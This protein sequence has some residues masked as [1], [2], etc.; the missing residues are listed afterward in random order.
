MS[1]IYV[2]GVSYGLSSKDK[3]YS[4]TS[5]GKRSTSYNTFPNLINSGGIVVKYDSNGK[6]DWISQLGLSES[7]IC[8]D[9]NK[10]TYPV[11][12]T[13][14]DTSAEP[15]T[16]IELPA[17][18]PNYVT[19]NTNYV[20]VAG[21]YNSN[22][23]VY[24]GN[25]N[26]CLCS[27]DTTICLPLTNTDITNGLF[28][29]EY[30]TNGNCNWIA[31]I[32]FN[33]VDCENSVVNIDN[34]ITDNTYVYL[35]GSYSD[36]SFYLYNGNSTNYSSLTNTNVANGLFLTQYDS[37]GNCSWTA[38]ITAACGSGYAANSI[39]AS[40]TSFT[41]STTSYVYIAAPYKSPVLFYYGNSSTN[42]LSLKNSNV[43]N[44][45]FI[46]KYDQNGSALSVAQ[47]T[48]G[49]NSI[50]YNYC[51]TSD[52]DGNIYVAGTYKSS[53]FLIYNGNSTS[54]SCLKNPTI[55]CGAF[56]V[57][58]NSDLFFDYSSYYYWVAQIEIFSS[59]D[60]LSSD[61]DADC[62]KHHRDDYNANEK[63]IIIN[64]IVTDSHANVYI[65]VLCNKSINIY[66]G[67]STNYITLTNDSNNKQIFI[68]KYNNYGQ[69]CW[70]FKILG[71]DGFNFIHSMSID[72][73]RNLGITGEFKGKYLYLYNSVNDNYITIKNTNKDYSNYTNGIFIKYNSCGEYIFNTQYGSSKNQSASF[74]GLSFSN[75]VSPVIP[76]VPC[77][78]TPCS[79]S[80]SSSPASSP[81]RTSQSCSNKLTITVPTSPDR[82]RR[83]S[84][85]HS[86]SPSPPRGRRRRSSNSHSR[87]PSPSRRPSSR[88]CSP[89]SE[90]SHVHPISN[91][92][93]VENTPIS[94]DQGVIPIQEIDT[95]LHTIHKK[96][97]IAITKTISNDKFLVAFKKHSLSSNYPSKKTIMTQRHKILYKGEL[98]E[99][100]NFVDN[101]T[102]KKIKNK[103]NILYNIL[104]ETYDTV[105]VNNLICETLHPNNIISKLYRNYFNDES[106]T[107]IIIKMNDFIKKKDYKSYREIQDNLN[108]F[109]NIITEL[110]TDK[111][112]KDEE[113]NLQIKQLEIKNA[114][115]IE[116]KKNK[117][118]LQNKLQHHK[119]CITAFKNQRIDN[120]NNKIGNYYNL[121]KHL[122]TDN[123]DNSNEFS[124]NDHEIIEPEEKNE[125]ITFTQEEE[126]RL[127]IKNICNK[128][129]DKYVLS[130]ECDFKELFKKIG[131][132][133]REIIKLYDTNILL[134]KGKTYQKEIKIDNE[135]REIALIEKEIEEEK[136]KHKEIIEEM[137]SFKKYKDELKYI[138][139][140]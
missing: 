65:S 66:N 22:F 4:A 101:Y 51:T 58:Y 23:N 94:T 69:Y 42:C 115:Y 80:P 85:S 41:N 40:M 10:K 24:Y 34:I 113:Y 50:N 77:V 9:I 56:I 74:L 137:D 119:S 104:M 44:G 130:L 73:S 91:I 26:Y 105:K 109:E 59:A 102:V 52:S 61:S 62:G 118:M 133:K 8:N 107:K 25:T 49:K 6:C 126:I 37:I 3:L 120:I 93:F 78:P 129:N 48:S 106:K 83:S 71:S 28:L 110:E 19:A 140:L 88:S 17:A 84:K 18:M 1:D 87:S 138:M 127:D 125:V 70:H 114:E 43:K 16:S 111:Q 132:K 92:C 112:L 39:V 135:N 103:G 15:C 67:S 128:L 98:T 79:K 35:L 75:A 5:S 30:N 27:T 45:V 108:I 82:R 7:D 139:D 14:S 96:K 97:I 90:R 12:D 38:Q 32:G 55:T 33:Y 134:L 57:K 89:S 100:V 36:S 136:T 131:R 64:N 81:V 46:V 13:D 95:D 72:S 20:Y 86:R 68:V 122:T 54:Y 117:M 124:I 53:S 60:D 123:A 11:S 31:Q 116:S 29:I 121:Y 2:S 76:E 47:I 21:K 99:A 63:R